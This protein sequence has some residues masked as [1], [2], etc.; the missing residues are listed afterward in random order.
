MY[1]IKE[2]TTHFKTTGLQ[3][4]ALPI[5]NI[6]SFP[7]LFGLTQAKA[8]HTMRILSFQM[9]SIAFK[10]PT[11]RNTKFKQ[12]PNLLSFELTHTL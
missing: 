6:W 5:L 7:K 2:H 4:P 10:L 8:E 3:A 12:H 9:S 11:E 1:F